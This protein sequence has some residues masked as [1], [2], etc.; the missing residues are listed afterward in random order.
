MKNFDSR[1]YSISDIVEWHERGLLNLSPDFQRRSV[2]PR[3]AKSFLIDTIVRGKPM[4]KILMTQ[5]LASGR[6]IRTVVDGQ[7]RVRAIIEYYNDEFPISPAHNSG[8]ARKKYGQLTHEQQS[9]F[10]SYEI[11]CDMLFNMSYSELLD[12]FTRINTYT[13]KLN[14]Q[15]LLNANYLGFFKQVSYKLGRAYVEYFVD[16][17]VLTKANVARMGEARLASDLVISI[18]DHI[19]TNK[20]METFYKRYEDEDPGVG[21]ICAKFDEI[22]SFVGAIYPSDELKNTFWSREVT[23][24]SLFTSIKIALFGTE[25][26]SIEV[27]PKLTPKLVGKW[28]FALDQIGQLNDEYPARGEEINFATKEVRD[29]LIASRRAT[30]DSEARI[31]RT[32]FILEQVATFV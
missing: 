30:T 14:S 15:E 23:F 29:F 25:L 32:K 2:W 8:L 17:G 16:G 10:L 3:K 18:I 11:S 1:T 26:K 24:Y 4:P 22:M 5:E 21:N 27:I 31:V 7:Q 20:S 12:I 9:E 19:Q 28:R 13:L 6:N